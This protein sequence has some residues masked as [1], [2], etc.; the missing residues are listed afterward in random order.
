MPCPRHCWAQSKQSGYLGEGRS[1]DAVRISQGDVLQTLLL[2]KAIFSADTCLEQKPV[3][4]IFRFHNDPGFL[5]LP[6]VDLDRII[7]FVCQS[8]PCSRIGR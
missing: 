6:V 3:G 2:L 7:K 4:M 8:R 1:V 5:T